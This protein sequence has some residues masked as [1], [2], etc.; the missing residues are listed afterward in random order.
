MLALAKRKAGDRTLKIDFRHWNVHQLTEVANSSVDAYAI[1][2]GMKICDRVLVLQEAFRVL[3]PG[4][5]I[6]CLEA[7]RI[8]V[9]FI[10]SAHLCYMDWCLPLIA[11][12]ATGGDRGAYDY[13]L[14][15]VHDFPSAPLLAREIE[16]FGFQDA[17]YRYMTF[18]IVALHVATKP[19]GLKL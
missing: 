6:Y 9:G 2:F 7:S 17:S 4:G 11:R 8:P 14:R 12:I 13:L 5:R 16:S 3:K 1:S 18:G 15:G 10:H 19:V